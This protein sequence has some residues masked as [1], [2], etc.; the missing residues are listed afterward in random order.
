[1]RFAT[2]VRKWEA[3][4]H[5]SYGLSANIQL[6]IFF[7]SVCQT[8]MT[9]FISITQFLFVLLFIMSVIFYDFYW[10]I[11]WKNWFL[12]ATIRHAWWY[13]NRNVQSKILAWN[14]Y[15][16]NEGNGRSFKYVCTTY[17]VYFH[18]IVKFFVIE[19]AI[20]FSGYFFATQSFNE[21][22]QK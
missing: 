3:L 18:W 10:V 9:I 1:M 22:N 17:I 13:L 20:D 14:F 7:Y 5:S 12:T 11:N 6:R 16:K 15:E 4:T 19:Y 21:K 8:K 2:L